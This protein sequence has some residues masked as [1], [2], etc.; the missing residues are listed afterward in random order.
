MSVL[1]RAKSP[2][3]SRHASAAAGTRGSRQSNA[4]GPTLLP[5]G[6]RSRAARPRRSDGYSTRGSSIA[7]KRPGLRRRHLH[8]VLRALTTALG[9]YAVVAGKQLDAV[10]LHPQ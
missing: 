4:V 8:R 3:T 9:W 6:A 1:W 10:L 7:D 2:P 5:R